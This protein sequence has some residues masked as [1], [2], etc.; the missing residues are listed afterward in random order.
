M[1]DDRFVIV[2]AVPLLEMVTFCEVNPDPRATLN[3]SGFGLAL[4]PT[5]VELVPTLRMTFKICADPL[6]V[7][8]TCAL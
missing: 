2:A 4:R 1:V 3:V 6:T 5:P 7:K 8:G